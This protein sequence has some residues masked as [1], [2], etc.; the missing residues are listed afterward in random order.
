MAGLL[1]TAAGA[2][3]IG[4]AFRLEQLKAWAAQGQAE[5]HLL[6]MEQ[7]LRDFPKIRISERFTKLLVNGAKLREHSFV[8][9]AGNLCEGEIAAVYDS[10]GGLAGLYTVRQDETGIYIKP[11][12]ML[13]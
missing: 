6:S 7:A 2:F 4:D 11:L 9:K 10:K 1:R 3:S 5:N 12:K 8:E 13:I